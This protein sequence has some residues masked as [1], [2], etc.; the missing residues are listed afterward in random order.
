MIEIPLR[1]QRFL[2]RSLRRSRKGRGEQGYLVDCNLQPQCYILHT[3]P[4]MLVEPVFS[5]MS[6]ELFAIIAFRNKSVGPKLK[7]SKDHLSIH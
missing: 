6:S 5:L 7:K 1:Y 4:A 2:R 3:E